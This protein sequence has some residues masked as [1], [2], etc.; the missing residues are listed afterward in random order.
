[1]TKLR[2][3]LCSFFALALMLSSCT[4]DRIIEL[5]PPPPPSEEQLIAYWNFNDIS[6]PEALVVPTYTVSS[7][8]LTY[9]GDFYDEVNEGS[10]INLQNDDEAGAALRLRNPSEYFQI[11]V[12][13]E[14]HYAIVVNYAAMRTNSGAQFQKVYYSTDGN[15]FIDAGLNDLQ[16]DVQLD[17]VLHTIDFSAINA[18][19]NNPDFKVRLQFS[20]GNT[21]TSGNNRIDNLSISGKPL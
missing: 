20:E 15:T 12:S 8:E 2:N 9:N 21:N 13:T 14:G 1:M 19:A 3:I 16:F 7:P 6:S 18:A 5:G 11:D 10:D 17:W 4:K